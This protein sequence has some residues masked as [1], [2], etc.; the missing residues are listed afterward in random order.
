MGLR[1]ILLQHSND[2][3]SPVAYATLTLTDVERQYSQTEKEA[4]AVVWP[5]E[6]FHIYL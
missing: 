6:R 4:V 3:V 1:A 2:T 5:F